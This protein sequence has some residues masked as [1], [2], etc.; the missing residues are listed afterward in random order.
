MMYNYPYFSFPYFR[1]YTVPSY[2]YYY[3]KKFP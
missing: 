3:K 2:N 1:R